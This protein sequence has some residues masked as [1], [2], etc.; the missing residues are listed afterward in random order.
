LNELKETNDDFTEHAKNLIDAVTEG[1]PDADNLLGELDLD[2]D[3]LRRSA[4][5]IVA[6]FDEQ[7]AEEVEGDD[8]T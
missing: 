2:E 5:D 4:D 8:D 1:D 3:E 6:D 7:I